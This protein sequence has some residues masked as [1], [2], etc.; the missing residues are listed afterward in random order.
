MNDKI[1]LLSVDE[2]RELPVRILDCG[3]WW[4]LRSLGNLQSRAAYVDHDGDIDNQGDDVDNKY[5]GVRPVL[6]V[7]NIDDIDLSDY[8]GIE[9]I[10][11]SKYMDKPMLLAKEPI[12]CNRF[13]KKNNNYESSEIRRRLLDW[14][15]N[16]TQIDNL[17]HI[18]YPNP[19]DTMTLC[20]NKNVNGTLDY[21]LSEKISK[22]IDLYLR[23]QKWAGRHN[24]T[25]DIFNKYYVCLNDDECRIFGVF[26]SYTEP[27]VTYFSSREIAKQALEFFGDEIKELYG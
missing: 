7:E 9:W 3:Q 6:E 21:Q 13:D 27:M 11:I 14:Y 16:K 4:W 1:F 8:L 18:V 5:G 10:D 26:P 24:G 17:Y 12:F 22:R 20:I 23:M 2:A 25:F 19:I 15:N